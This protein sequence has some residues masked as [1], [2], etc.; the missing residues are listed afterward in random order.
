MAR[1]DEVTGKLSGAVGPVVL[2]NG[3]SGQIVRSKI[4]SNKSKSEAQLRQR[5]KMQA[6]SSFLR[7]LA[8][9]LKRLYVEPVGKSNYQQAA[10]SQA[11]RQAIGENGDL[12]PERVLISRGTMAQ[13]QDMRMEA[14]DDSLALS[15]TDNSHVGGANANDRLVV[16]LY[17]PELMYVY[18]FFT[19]TTR[20]QGTCRLDVSRCKKGDYL[21]YATFVAA[22]GNSVSNSCYVALL[23]R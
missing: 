1:I 12:V 21:V 10:L 7:P 4:T 11:M 18:D 17:D 14:E 13:P 6:A 9:V 2:V 16:V 15:W 22:K 3:K 20:C 23:S 5:A 8:E 19:E